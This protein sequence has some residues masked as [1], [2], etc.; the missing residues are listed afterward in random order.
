MNTEQKEKKTDVR[1]NDILLGPLERP[2]LAF[3]CRNMPSWVTPD[4]LTI[5]GVISF[6]LIGV[7]YYLANFSPWFLWLASFGLVL[8]WYGDSLDGSLARFR[9]IERPKF[10]Y[11]VDHIAD[12]YATAIIC[13]GIGLSPYVDFSF[14]MLILVGYLLMSIL[15]YI[16]SNVTG[17]FKISYGKFG[18][19]EMRVLVILVNMYF[20]WGINPMLNLGLFHIKFLNL[21]ALAV[22]VFLYVL[23]IIHSLKPLGEIAKLDKPKE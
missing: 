3:F 17:I 22:A 5:L 2:A 13:I 19:T 18:P 9:K 20:F 12:A 11:Y 4:H 6:I 8:H 7:S 16:T 21:G 14:A 10:G 23:F 1:V 15:V